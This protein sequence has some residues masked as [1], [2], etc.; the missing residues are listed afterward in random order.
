MASLLANLQ[1]IEVVDMGS[2]LLKWSLN[3]LVFLDGLEMDV[4]SFGRPY[5]NR[6]LI[7]STTFLLIISIGRFNTFPFMSNIQT[8]TLFTC[9]L[10]TLQ[11]YLI[12]SSTYAILNCKNQIDSPSYHS[13]SFRK[14]AS[15]LYVI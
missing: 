4:G 7:R 12:K 10:R 8:Q 2:W 9:V 11:S 5:W 6:N 15:L 1:G 3:A 13:L 14:N